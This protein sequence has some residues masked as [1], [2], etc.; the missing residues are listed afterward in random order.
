MSLSEIFFTQNELFEKCLLFIILVVGLTIHE[1]AHAFSADK[2]GDPL[3]RAE[4]RVTLDPR[5]HIDL[6][7]T[8]ILPMIM[9]FFNPGFAVFRW[10]KPVR[11][12]LSKK[13]NQTRD[14]ILITLAG[15]F[16]NL[17]IALLAT[18]LFAALH[19]IQV[20]NE[21]MLKLFFIIININCILFLF[22]MIPVP[23]LDG[24]HILK[25]AVKMS[26][27]TFAKFSG[28]GIII[29]LLLV[30]IDSFMDFFTGLLSQLT[31]YFFSL[32]E[33]LSE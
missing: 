13:E 22:N 9:I 26:E 20:L 33:L 4:G 14:D 2:L 10:G 5:S 8:I 30:N 7:G 32:F 1:W 28:F 23:P 15:P 21:A 18:F 12:S 25:R 31:Y 6:V 3:P 16:S 29:I 11:V 27:I 17:C 19:N 24:S